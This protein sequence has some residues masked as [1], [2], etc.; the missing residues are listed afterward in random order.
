[1]SALRLL[2]LA[3]LIAAAALAAYG[4]RRDSP[5]QETPPAPDSEPVV[6]VIDAKVPGT[7]VY[8]RGQLLGEVPLELTAGRLRALGIDPADGPLDEDGWA[9][10]L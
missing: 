1:M 9:E 8:L 3:F 6:A 5:L 10:A 7:R 4:L 2:I